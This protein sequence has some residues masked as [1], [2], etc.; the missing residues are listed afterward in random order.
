MDRKIFATGVIGLGAMGAP[1]AARLRECGALAGVYARTP[2]KTAQFSA[3]LA[4][5]AFASATAAARGCE[6]LLLSLP[7]DDAVLAVTAEIARAAAP[8]RLV[9]DTSTVAP[10]TAGA[11]AEVLARVGAAYVEAPVTGGVEAACTGRL[12]FFLAGDTAAIERAQPLLEILGSR[13]TH[14]GAIGSGQRAKAANQLMI[15]GINQALCEALA[16]AE[17]LEV[18]LERFI[19]ATVDGA[20]GSELLRRRGAALVAQEFAPGFRIAL[21]EKDLRICQTLA[22]EMPAQLPL[23]EMTLIHYRRLT[24]QGLGDAD[25]SALFM[26]KQKLFSEKSKKGNATI[27]VEHQPLPACLTALGVLQWPIWTKEPSKFPWTYEEDETCY[28]L[29]GEV[30]VTPANG[31]PVTIGRN[32][33]VTFPAG[34]VC[35]W[36]I[37]SPVRKHYAFGVSL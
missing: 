9:V 5:T 3:A 22:A 2:E 33:L 7:D 30:V 34:L 17:A 1:M 31:A 35:T 26:Q 20:A 32:D 29:E 28:F 27:K 6:C 16:F 18:P 21:H 11:A 37:V 36:E 13:H 23:A 25:I 12:S 24:A 10:A 19:A 15:A 4:V 14:F 8:G